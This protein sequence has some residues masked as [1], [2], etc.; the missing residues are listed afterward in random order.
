MYIGLIHEDFAFAPQKKFLKKEIFV[1]KTKILL[2]N[3][4]KRQN[5]KNSCSVF[6]KPVITID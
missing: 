5:K 6:Q 3:V 1:K 2:T 4:I